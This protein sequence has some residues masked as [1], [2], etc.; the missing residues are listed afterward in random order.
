MRYVMNREAAFNIFAVVVGAM[1][2][3]EFVVVAFIL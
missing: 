2:P 1:L 3:I